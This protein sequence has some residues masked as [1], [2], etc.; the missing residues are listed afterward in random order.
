MNPQV[1]IARTTLLQHREVWT[2]ERVKWIILWSFGWFNF[3]FFEPVMWQL[4]TNAFTIA[5]SGLWLWRTQFLINRID[6]LLRYID[7]YLVQN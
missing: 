7:T 3:T 4:I 1:A 2:K 6:E 5:L